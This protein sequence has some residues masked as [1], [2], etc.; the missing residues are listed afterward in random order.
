MFYQKKKS[1]LLKKN[2]TM[3]F[4]SKNNSQ[5]NPIKEKFYNEISIKKKNS[6]QNNSQQNPY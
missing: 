3:K 2:S 6:Q 1:F 5:Q 4:L